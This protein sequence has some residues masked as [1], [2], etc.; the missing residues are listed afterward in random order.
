M[1][2]EEVRNLHSGD[3]VFWRDPDNKDPESDCS[4]FITIATIEIKGTA[5][6]IT[7]TDGSYLECWAHELE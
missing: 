4:R 1:T 2:L 3:K 5:I 6:L 7:G